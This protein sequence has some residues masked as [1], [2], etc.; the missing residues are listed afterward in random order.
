MAQTAQQVE[1]FRIWDLPTRIFHWL[2]VAAVGFLLFTGLLAPENWLDLHRYAGYSVAALLALRMIWWIYGTGYSRLSTLLRNAS[3]LPSFL[4]A[5]LRL[6][7]PHYAGHNPAGSIMILALLVALLVLVISGFLVEGGEEKLG[8]LAGVTWFSTGAL[9]HVVHEWLAYALIA[10]I[11]LHIAGVV[12]ETWVQKVPLVRGMIT[13]Q[14]PLP[15]NAIGIDSLRPQAHTAMIAVVALAMFAA[16][17]GYVLLRLPPLGVKVVAANVAYDKECSACH[18][19]F[20]PSLLPK[21]SWLA[22]MQ[23][24]D[25]HFGEDASLPDD[26]VAAISEFLA[27]NAAETTDTEVANRFR[28]VSAEAPL[29][30][31]KTPFW[32]RTHSGISE[33]MFSGAVVK[34]KSNCAACHSDAASGRFDDSAIRTVPISVTPEGG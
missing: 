8:P 5:L 16:A 20:H 6:K 22:I 2:L 34:S 24:L 17:A 19:A 29:F 30:I 28:D 1:N 32:Q 11:I 27:A 31:T 26:K 13:G 33:A 7:P 12:F 21:A 9:A 10:M 14:L 15:A 25:D 23:G 4:P 3:H 18:A